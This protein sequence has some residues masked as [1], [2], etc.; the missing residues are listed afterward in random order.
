[1]MESAVNSTLEQLERTR[2]YK[3]YLNGPLAAADMTSDERADHIKEIRQMEVELTSWLREAKAAI[4][5]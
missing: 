4:R 1:M 2:A 5:Q 3:K